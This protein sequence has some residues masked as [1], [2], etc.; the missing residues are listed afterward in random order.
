MSNKPVMHTNEPW[1]VDE[2]TQIWAPS[3]G[4]Y[5]AITDCEPELNLVPREVQEANARRIVSCVNACA[6]IDTEIIERNA[7]KV[8]DLLTQR[9]EL[10]AA[11][12]G[13][14]LFTKPMK[15]NAVALNHCM[16]LIERIE[17]P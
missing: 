7:N 3:I 5:V 4:Q 2:P 9:D 8:S 6:G 15:S 13:L 14:M 12:K 16:R 10:L 1:Q 17:H 11:L